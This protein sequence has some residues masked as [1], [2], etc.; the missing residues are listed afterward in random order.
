ML[1]ERREFVRETSRCHTPCLSH[2][3]QPATLTTVSSITLFSS[4]RSFPPLSPFHWLNVHA[5]STW[6][7][8]YGKGTDLRIRS[9]AGRWLLLSTVGEC[10]YRFLLF[11]FLCAYKH[12][13]LFLL[14]FTFTNIRSSYNM[15]EIHF[16]FYNDT[17]PKF[18][19]SMTSGL[20]G[21]IA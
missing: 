3:V 8:G 2:A 12:K 13:W 15:L 20:R 9:P 5:D 16:S 11:F 19:T 4:S 21:S 7:E 18:N 1:L 6:R 17:F 14:Y 10:A